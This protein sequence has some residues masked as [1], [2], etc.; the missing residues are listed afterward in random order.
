MFDRRNLTSGGVGSPVHKFEGHN[1]A[2][3][4]V[5]VSEIFLAIFL[6]FL[7]FC[8]IFKK[9]FFVGFAFTD[10]YNVLVSSGLQ[11]S[12]PSLEVLLRMAF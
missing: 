6:I 4:C 5:Q 8:L 1:A 12:H 11:T 10:I 3:L 2:V 9:S 7:I